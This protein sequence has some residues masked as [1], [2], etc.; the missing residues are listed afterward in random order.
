MCEGKS[1]GSDRGSRKTRLEGYGWVIRMDTQPRQSRGNGSAR[2]LR[3]R[4]GARSGSL[5]S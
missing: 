4:H 3:S 1:R 2:S 5:D